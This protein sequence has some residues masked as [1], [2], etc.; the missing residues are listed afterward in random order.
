MESHQR[1]NWLR[2]STKSPLLFHCQIKE[3]QQKFVRGESIF[4]ELG[5]FNILASRP[6]EV[7]VEDGRRPEFQEENTIG[8][9]GL[10]N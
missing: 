6:T 3:D 2:A 4:E 1:W 7:V 8:L 10:G 9:Y 5:R